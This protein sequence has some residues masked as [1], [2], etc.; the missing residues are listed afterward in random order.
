MI[1]KFTGFERDYITEIRARV[2]AGQP[3]SAREKQVVLDIIR[4]AGVAV[5]PAVLEAAN[6]NGF[7]TQGIAVN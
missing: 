3:V 6:R 7:A 5:N 1:E 2:L 4:L